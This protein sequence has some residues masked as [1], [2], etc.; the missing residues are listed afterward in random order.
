VTIN[1]LQ[2]RKVSIPS[3]TAVRTGRLL[4]LLFALFI[5]LYL[6]VFLHEA[7]H[8]V[9]G[10]LSGG[11]ITTFDADFL[12]SSARVSF[13]GEFSHQQQTFIYFA[14]LPLPLI[15][16]LSFLLL[17]PRR[18]NA[19]IE[20]LKF[21]STAAALGTLIPWI[22][23]PHLYRLDMAPPTDDVT[24]FLAGSGIDPVL[25]MAAAISILFLGG[26]F[27][28]SRMNGIIGI[29]KMLYSEMATSSAGF[30]WT[31]FVMCLVIGLI[32]TLELGIGR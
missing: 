8:A 11:K 19:M 31:L 21:F 29:R 24:R 5:V 23:I 28:S 2:E 26:L 9:A 14:G 12:T 1:T 17:V 10:H 3:K 18:S 30:R 13:S 27:S 6:V 7:G 22:V 20:S 25:V 32:G 16:W 4:H 15:A